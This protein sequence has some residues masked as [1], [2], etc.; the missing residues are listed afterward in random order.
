MLG[1]P[2]SVSPCRATG[3]ED[4]QMNEGVRPLLSSSGK[5]LSQLTSEELSEAIR[6][7]D[8]REESDLPLLKALRDLRAERTRTPVGS[9]TPEERDGSGPPLLACG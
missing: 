3:E 2:V 1:D 8:A 7:L 9:D 5:P 6:Y 4:V